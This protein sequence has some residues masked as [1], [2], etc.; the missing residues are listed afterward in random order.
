[1]WSNITWTF[2]ENYLVGIFIDAAYAGSRGVH[3]SSSN[4][5]SINNLPDSFYAQVQQQI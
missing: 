2:K 3:L 5:V 1:M 4:N